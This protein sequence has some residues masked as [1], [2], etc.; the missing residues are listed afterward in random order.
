MNFR[1]MTALLY[2]LCASAGSMAQEPPPVEAAPIVEGAEEIIVTGQRL[3]FELRLQ[4]QDAERAVYNLFN[5]LND[6]P[7]FKISCSMHEITGTRLASQVCQPEFER[8]ALAQEGQDYLAA[9][10]AFRE[11]QS[12]AD[13]VAPE[14][15]TMAMPAAGIIAP[16]QR[17]LQRKMR[18]VADEHP[19]FIDALVRFV[20]AKGR[21]EKSRDTASETEETP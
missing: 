12:C 7:R 8:I 6:E 4:M 1:T 2:V 21:Y 10:R 17:E 16:Q 11:A 19:E 9:Y 3:R 13:C 15:F 20:E 14:P 18:E 5:E